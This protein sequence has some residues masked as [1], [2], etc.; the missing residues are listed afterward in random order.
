MIARCPST[1]SHTPS[2]L[3]LSS[4]SFILLTNLPSITSSV[5]FI[6]SV[7][8][9]SLWPMDCSRPGFPVHH[10]FPELAQTDVH[11]VGDA[12]QPS[13]PLLSPSPPAFNLSQHQ[14]LFQWVI[15]SHQMT[16]SF[17]ISPSSDYS[18][19][20]SLKIDWFDLFTVQGTLSC[21]LQH[22]SLKASILWCSVFFTIQLSQPYMTTGKT[23]NKPWLYKPLSA[24]TL[25]L[26]FSKH[27]LG[28]S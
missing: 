23:I 26:C 28:L 8:S 15:C 6:H 13:H 25:R 21:L 11:W 5:Q 14:G 4:H 10:Q 2:Y 22:H 20:F 18:G 12:I 19:L 27:C 1:P 17:S 7:V 16:N 24:E 3:T 9:N